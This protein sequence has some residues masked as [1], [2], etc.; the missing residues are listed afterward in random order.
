[1]LRFRN[2]DVMP[3]KLVQAAGPKMLLVHPKMSKVASSATVKLTQK[4]LYR[5][6]TKPGEDY[7]WA[8]TMKTIGA[9]NV[10]R[11]TVRVK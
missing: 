8:G 2:N 6:T 9:D 4:G 3:H 10:L 5:F 7:A 1:M 11:L